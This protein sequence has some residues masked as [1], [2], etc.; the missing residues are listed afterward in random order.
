MNEGEDKGRWI[1]RGEMGFIR[2][3]GGY[4]SDASDCACSRG[5]LPAQAVG[6]QPDQHHRQRDLFR[7]D[8][9]YSTV[10]RGAVGLGG[11]CCL[12]LLCGC[13]AMH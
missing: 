9:A 12:L 10:Q 6:H 13:G 1:G 5:G 7:T 2:D 4:G 3:G 8:G 11:L